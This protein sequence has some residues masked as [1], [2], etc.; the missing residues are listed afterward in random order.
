MAST[1]RFSLRRAGLRD[2]GNWGKCTG[3]WRV[4]ARWAAPGLGQQRADPQQ[5]PPYALPPPTPRLTTEQPRCTA[6]R[7]TTWAALT[8]CVAA[9]A[10]MAGW[11]SACHSKSAS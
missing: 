5:H 2:L 1:A 7:S 6:Q 9:M 11:R 10:L 8:P 4:V 3:T